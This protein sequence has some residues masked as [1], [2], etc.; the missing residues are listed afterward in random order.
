VRITNVQIHKSTSTHDLGFPYVEVGVGSEDGNVRETHIPLEF[1]VELHNVASRCFIGVLWRRARPSYT[2][3]LARR[4]ARS[5]DL[6]RAFVRGTTSLSRNFVNMIPC[7]SGRSSHHRVT[8]DIHVY[9]AS[10]F[11]NL[12]DSSIVQDLSST[13]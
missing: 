10:L 12:L 9:S 4:R 11:L 1:D 3:S 8:V 6:R 5:T 2:R 13:L 7:S